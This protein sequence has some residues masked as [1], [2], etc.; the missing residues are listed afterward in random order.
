M[1]HGLYVHLCMAVSGVQHRSMARFI[2]SGTAPKSNIDT[3]NDGFCLRYLLSNMAILDIYIYYLCEIS[4]RTTSMSNL[5][6]WDLF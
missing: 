2:E 1:P 3:K 4:G 5:Q 6:K